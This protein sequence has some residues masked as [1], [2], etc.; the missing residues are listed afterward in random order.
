M[1]VLDEV[2]TQPTGVGYFSFS[3]DGC[4]VYVTGD[5]HEF[6]Q[7]LVWVADGR[8]TPLVVGERL[9]EE[10]RLSPDGRRIAFGIRQA[11]SDIWIH[12]IEAGT[13]RR[14]TFEG[15]NFA[16]VWSPDGRRLTFS[17]N[18]NGPCQIFSQGLEDAEP[19][20]L[21]SGEHD[22]VPGSWL[23]DGERLLFT[24]YSPTTGAGVWSC[25]PSGSQP[26]RLMVPSHGHA[27][28]PIV[29]RDGL[30]FAYTSDASGRSE[31]Y[32]GMLRNG[33]ETAQITTEGGSEPVWSADGGG[34]YFR[35]GSGVARVDVDPTTK[36]RTSSPIPVADGPYQPGAM[37]G[38]PN[39]DVA[40]DGRLLLVAQR[41]SDVQPDQLAVTVGWFVEILRRL[42]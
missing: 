34:L 2:M 4:L 20:L 19:T 29:S 12:E 32:V 31:V 9:I 6:V 23:P 30:A 17:S 11:T 42:A 18:R 3:R 33:G 38:L 16:P 41:S 25:A 14:A 36:R 13:L 5:A 40:A 27:F 21:L 22:L 8:A 24:E 35:H 15:D 26:P 39:Y 10:P 1:P 28:A 37:T 7:R